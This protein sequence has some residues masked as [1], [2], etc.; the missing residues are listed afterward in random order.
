MFYNLK[1]FNFFQIILSVTS[2]RDSLKQDFAKL[3]QESE[4]KEISLKRKI[5]Y[6]IIEFYIFN[7]WFCLMC[8]WSAL[9]W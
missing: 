2:E 5:D 8:T 6:H 9:H 7:I 4:D 3:Q 1:L